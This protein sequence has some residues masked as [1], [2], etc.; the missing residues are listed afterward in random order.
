MANGNSTEDELELLAE[1]ISQTLRNFDLIDELAAQHDEQSEL[2]GISR[3]G[4][5]MSRLATFLIPIPTLN[6]QKRIVKKVDEL[7]T[8]CDELESRLVQSKQESE[9]LMQAVLQEALTF[10][11]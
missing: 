5:S 8:L 4:L 9:K 6:E 11:R 2:I 1:N 7:M 10:N 3:E